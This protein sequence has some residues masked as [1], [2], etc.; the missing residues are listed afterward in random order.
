LDKTK[1]KNFSVETLV[2]V[3]RLD[4]QGRLLET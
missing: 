4:V 1:I 3:F 2:L